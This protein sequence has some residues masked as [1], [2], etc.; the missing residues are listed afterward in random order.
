MVHIVQLMEREIRRQAFLNLA[1]PVDAGKSNR[2][3]KD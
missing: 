1:D 2:G 3:G